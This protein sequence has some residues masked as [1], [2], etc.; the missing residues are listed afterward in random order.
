MTTEFIADT[1]LFPFYDEEKTLLV[2][3]VVL[4][5]YPLVTGQRQTL[6]CGQ[7]A[8]FALR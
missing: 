8:H 7:S 1:H 2:V 4:R 6:T 3:A 5:I